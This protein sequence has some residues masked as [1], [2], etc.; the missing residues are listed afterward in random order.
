MFDPTERRR[1]LDG[2]FEVNASTV[3]GKALLLV[4]DLYRSGATMAAVT[5]VLLAAGASKIHAFAFT[6]TRT[7]T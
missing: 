2:A 7:K 4:D 3:Q 1:L 5:E 6:Q